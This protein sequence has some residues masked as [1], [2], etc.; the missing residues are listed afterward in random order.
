[1]LT[2]KEEALE[3][4]CPFTSINRL[5]R[6]PGN[7]TPFN[8]LIDADGEVSFPDGAKCIADRCMAWEWLDYTKKHGYCGYCRVTKIVN[9]PVQPGAGGPV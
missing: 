2:T 4:W 1:M 8:R 9:N 3:K 7:V 5:M 6:M